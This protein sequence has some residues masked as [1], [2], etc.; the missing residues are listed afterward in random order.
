MPLG[1]SRTLPDLTAG[2]SSTN[3][4]VAASVSGISSEGS[5]IR[6]EQ[7]SAGS[8]TSNGIDPVPTTLSITG[9]LDLP[10]EATWSLQQF[11][12]SGSFS[13]Y[14]Y[15]TLAAYD[16]TTD[17][18]GASGYAGKIANVTTTDTP[19]PAIVTAIA[20]D[21]SIIRLSFNSSTSPGPLYSG[22]PYQGATFVDNSSGTWSGTVTVWWN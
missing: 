5:V 3:T 17:Y 10:N 12:A 18:G 11:S 16:G 6:W 15:P 21:A 22:H 1:S 4:L 2:P 19:L 13:T 7:T 8:Y 14:V 20:K 9:Q